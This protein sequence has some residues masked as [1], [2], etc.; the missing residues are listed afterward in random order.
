[1]NAQAAQKALLALQKKKAAKPAKKE[2]SDGAEITRTVTTPQ[3]KEPSN[4][5]PETP[6]RESPG[7]VSEISIDLIKQA[8]ASVVVGKWTGREK[9]VESGWCWREKCPNCSV[10]AP[11]SNIAR[12]WCGRRESGEPGQKEGVV[13]KLIKE[14]VV[15]NQCPR[16]KKGEFTLDKTKETNNE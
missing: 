6:A 4:D 13:W 15:V 9:I 11:G 1:M 3:H 7:A 16:L 5:Q 10:D 12:W 8:P 2:S 14:G